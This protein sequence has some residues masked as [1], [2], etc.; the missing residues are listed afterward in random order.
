MKYI[1][2]S[3]AEGVRINIDFGRYQTYLE[4]IKNKLPAHIYSFASNPCYFDFESRSSLHDA[5]LETVTVQEAASG[6]R[7]QFRRLEVCVCLLGPFHDRRIKLRYTA[8]LNIILT[9]RRD[10]ENHATTIPLMEIC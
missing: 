1:T 4:S 6:Q 2:N 3:E 5:W 8:L 9:R 7:K 10:T